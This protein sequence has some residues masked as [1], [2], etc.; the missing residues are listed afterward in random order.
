MEAA[1]PK[2]VYK[3]PSYSL[4]KP[5]GQAKVR[6]NGKTTYLGKFGTAESHQRYADFIARIPKPEVTVVAEPAPGASLLVGE[7]VLRYYQHAQT[8][9]VRDGVPT[10][11]HET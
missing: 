8:Y 6:F 1:M 9:Y 4:H 5:S 11:E 7:V 2:L 3:L 10:G